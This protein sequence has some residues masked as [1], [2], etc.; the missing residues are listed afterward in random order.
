M[1]LPVSI[2]EILEGKYRIERVIGE[3]GMGVVVAAEHL[4]LQ[5]AVA[6]KFL[7]VHQE[8]TLRE[9][10][11][12][13][14]RAASRIASEHVA[15]VHDVGTLADGTPYMVMELLKGMDLDE[16]VRQEGPLPIPR[17]VTFLL[18]ACE[19]LAEAHSVGIVHRDLKPANLFLAQRPDGRE[20]IKLLDF[21][22]SK[23]LADLTDSPNPL[24]NTNSILGSPQFMAPEQLVSSR[25]VD[26][27][28]D[29]WSLGIVLHE[30][31]T[32][33][34]AF[35]APTVVEMYSAI[36]RDEPERVRTTRPDVPAELE[37]IILRCLEKD[38]ELRFTTIA[39]LTDGLAPF[40]PPEAQVS[41]QRVQ[42]VIG[43]VAPT[44]VAPASAEPEPA[45]PAGSQSGSGTLVTPEEPAP[46][47]YP[48][49]S[50]GRE[51]PPG[52][53]A[54]T[55]PSAATAAIPSSPPMPHTTGAPV[56]VHQGRPPMA[57]QALPN[58]PAPGPAA[59]H[60]PRPARRRWLWIAGALGA[61]SLVALLIVVGVTR[62]GSE[63]RS[64]D[65]ETGV[66]SDGR[67]ESKKSSGD[68]PRIGESKLLSR[69][70]RR[71]ANLALRRGE[72]ELAD[73]DLKQADERAKQ[74]LD[75]LAE[76][77]VKPGTQSVVGARAQR[78]RAAVAVAHLQKTRQACRRVDIAAPSALH[79]L[80]DAAKEVNFAHGA[81]SE[82]TMVTAYWGPTGLVRCAYAQDARL[83]VDT[84]VLYLDL[85]AKRTRQ[86]R[87]APD[88]VA[89][90]LIGHAAGR[91]II[92]ESHAKSGPKLAPNV[93]WCDDVLGS[94]TR[95]IKVQRK[96]LQQLK[97]R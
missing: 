93:T 7:R 9:R 51:P 47:A 23:Q 84:A 75:R 20:V 43:A 70:E 53:A 17:A 71:R 40:A 79:R 58:L 52:P 92:A 38:A 60:G 48:P 94:V 21:G 22:V 63:Q 81:A 72:R 26:R 35:P 33:R 90:T 32:A 37:T 1:N 14:A 85:A 18:Q 49:P 2:G 57:A 59:T 61:A 19:A 46:A 77:G 76:L 66:D 28:A 34:P 10:F 64:D 78:L 73:H 25:D 44:Q 50:D 30:L 62:L 13:E 91:L 3:G 65:E 87:K 67:N 74:V 16:L 15:R 11:L 4:T 83:N 69:A 27:R 24:T 68:K 55:L 12:R 39:E 31:L 29:I 89:E 56:V 6:I 54:V 36:L 86:P 45:P 41:A 95:R 42:R 8:P 5:Q 82:Q 97:S 88:Y 96:R 80:T